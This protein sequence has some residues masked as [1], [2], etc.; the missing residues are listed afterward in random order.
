M[1]EIIVQRIL[2]G[3][4]YR[5][6]RTW[7]NG[8]VERTT[9]STR[10]KSNRD[11]SDYYRPLFNFPGKLNPKEFHFGA[12]I[13]LEDLPSFNRFPSI[14]EQWLRSLKQFYVRSDSKFSEFIN[15]NSPEA[16]SALSASKLPD[17]SGIL[18]SGHYCVL[19]Y[20]SSSDRVG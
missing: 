12:L 16:R 13:N 8:R 6:T 10:V 17:S 1:N 2:F 7:M 20:F 19:N 15:E 4:L 11:L 9:R 3:H 5:Y 18:Y 14:H